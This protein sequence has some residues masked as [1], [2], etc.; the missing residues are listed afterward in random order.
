MPELHR[1][2]GYVFYIWSNDHDHPA[3]VHVEKGGGEADLELQTGKVTWQEGFSG[4]EVRHIERIFEENTQKIWS[5]WREWFGIQ[6][7]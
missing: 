1:E 4:K 7:P 6:N 2:N 3:H 5:G